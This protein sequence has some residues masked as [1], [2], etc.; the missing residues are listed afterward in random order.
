MIE[1]A[2]NFVRPPEAPVFE[3][4]SEEFENPLEYLSKIRPIAE[5][6]GICKIRP[7]AVRTLCCNFSLVIYNN[8]VLFV[9]PVYCAYSADL[10]HW[11]SFKNKHDGQKWFAPVAV[12]VKRMGSST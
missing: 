4:T 9:G 12:G 10:F 5:Q 2:Y 7:P 11:S 8:T 6:A 3:P 1:N